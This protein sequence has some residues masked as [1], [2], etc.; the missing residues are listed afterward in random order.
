MEVI[1]NI[2][3]TEIVILKF[4]LV[5]SK[6]VVITEITHD[7]VLGGYIYPRSSVSSH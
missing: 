1:L 3:I 5:F 6:F 4:T 2:A 7:W